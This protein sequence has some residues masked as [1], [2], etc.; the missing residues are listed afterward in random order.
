MLATGYQVNVTR[1]PFLA[2]DI[3]EKLLLQNG[4]PLLD[5]HF[6]SSVP[7]LYFSSFPAGHSFGP[8]FG[9]TVA[10]RTAAKLIG[11]ALLTADKLPDYSLAD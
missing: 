7:G 2:P 1:L 3:Q 5:L 4:F 11:H 6:Q 10:V 9:F 8:F